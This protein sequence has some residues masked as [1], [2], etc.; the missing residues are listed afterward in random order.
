MIHVCFGLHDKTGRYSKFTGTAMLSLFENV[1]TPPRLPSVTVHI[2]HDN[3]LTQDNR[4]KFIYLAGQYGQLVKFY[5]VEELCADKLAEF[6]KLIPAIKTSRLSI[7]AMYRLL[8]PQ[9]LPPEFDKVIYLDSDIVVNLD[10]TELWQIDLERKVFATVPEICNCVDTQN[11]LP[12]CRE[13][14]VKKE[15]YFNSGMMIMNLKSLYDQ[16]EDIMHGI[17]FIGENPRLGECLDQD[18]LNYLFSK[19]YIKLPEKFNYFVRDARYSSQIKINKKI[20]H[21]LGKEILLNMRDLFNR[22]WFRYFVK[23]PWFNE[24]TIGRLYENYRQLNNELKNS[25]ANVSAAMSGKTRAFF[26]VPQFVGLVRKV[27]SVRDDEEIILAENQE[28]LQKLINAMQ[29]SQGKKVFFIVINAFPFEVLAEAGFVYGRDFMNG[30]TFF[31]EEDG[32]F[33]NSYEIIKTL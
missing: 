16:E 24:D 5:N 4:D 32:A 7:A 27:F 28:S 17:K 8:I 2:L 14:Y 19:S 22:L 1:F 10:V 3:T 26:T 31:S 11:I 18:I 15:D 21:Y 29:R 12:L 9:L 23:T 20:Y 25:M 6:M 33:I 13:N 30:I